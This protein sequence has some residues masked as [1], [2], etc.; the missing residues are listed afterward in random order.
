MRNI[1]DK[2]GE[3]VRIGPRSVSISDKDMIKQ[4][5]LQ[6]DLPKG[7]AYSIFKSTT[8]SFP[9]CLL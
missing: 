8:C 9:E 1:H 5:L 7:P 6:D 3:V 4:V 2:Y